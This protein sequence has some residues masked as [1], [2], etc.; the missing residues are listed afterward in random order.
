MMPH[1]CASRRALQLATLVLAAGLAQPVAVALAQDLPRQLPGPAVPGRREDLPPPIQAPI[2]GDAFVLRLPPAA[3]PPPEVASQ[4]LMVADIRLTGVTVYGPGELRP[5]FASLLNR[6]ITVGAFYDIAA[7]IQARYRQDGY[8]LSFALVPPQTVEDGIFT[9]AVVEGYV[10][11]VI[12]EGIEG[13]L[14]ATLQRTVEP[15][16]RSRPLRVGDLERHLLL[17]NDLAG[18]AVTSVLR[19]SAGIRGASELVVR[20]VYAPVE[21]GLQ[22]DN[23]GSEYAGPVEGSANIVF[24][25]L[26]G[27]GEALA[28][29]VTTARPT[30]ELKALAVNY[31]HPLGTDG[32]RVWFS[33]NYS[34]AEPGSTLQAF[35]VKTHSLRA[36]LHMSY[37]VIRTRRESLY[38]DLGVGTVEADVDVL[39][40]RFSKDRLREALAGVTYLRNGILG[41][42]SGARLQM[43][44]GLPLFG[45]S[46]PDSDD[47]S[48]ADAQPDFTKLTLDI[49]HLQP[50]FAGFGLT[51]GAR[52]QFAPR[53]VPA[54]EEFALGR[55]R[56]GRAYDGGEVTGD[57]GVAVSLEL[58]HDLPLGGGPADAGTA[59]IRRVRPYIYYDAGKAWDIRSGSSVGL[60]QSLASAGF[61]L[62]LQTA[63]GG[64]LAVEYA[65]PLTRTPTETGDRNGQIL[66]AFEVDF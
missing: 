19:P 13:R 37:P 5:L 9:I 36:E 6:Q 64:E 22:L 58:G 60:A 16:S 50:L 17:A 40:Q 61:G 52:G 53:P 54:Q 23:R 10:D 8:L 28:L 46:D 21:G 41:G 59:L 24:N 51:V 27:L 63:Y 15:I 39:G 1:G 20:P 30:R 34:L 45:A 35:D 44:Q 48:R 26:L 65:R 3:T 7:A 47:T 56:F 11:K 18:I 57:R 4:P 12:V 25:S 38:L 14:A 2:P 32:L 62:R 33:L 66:F 43:I 55:S 29:Q 42:L 49:T 31:T